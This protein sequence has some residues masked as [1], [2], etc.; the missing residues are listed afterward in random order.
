M[1]VALGYCWADPV[2]GFAVTFIA[3]VGWGITALMT[4]PLM[5]A[6]PARRE[7]QPIRFVLVFGLVSLPADFVY[8][9]GRSIIGPYLGSLGAPGLAVGVVAGLGEA[10]ALVFRFVAGPWP[11]GPGA[12]GPSRS[13]ATS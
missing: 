2:A 3:H 9:G 7:V 13:A 4:A 1:G 12:S 10:T 5:D 11:I 6:V 8:E